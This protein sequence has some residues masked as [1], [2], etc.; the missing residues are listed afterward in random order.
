MADTEDPER[1][2]LLAEVSEPAPKVAPGSS[3]PASHLKAMSLILVTLQT[4][5]M[6]ILTRYTRVGGR[7]PYSI[8]S[9]VVM[10][11]CLKMVFS[12]GLLSMEHE[13]LSRTTSVLMREISHNRA[14]CF[15]LIVPA[16]LYFFQNNILIF[17]VTNLNTAQ[18]QVCYQFKLVVTGAL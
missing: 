2:R 15:K 12:M 18:Y 10:S 1:A 7:P 4:T 13:S 17:A 8:C 11:E 14:E 6:V 5:T 3:E 16:G 9:M